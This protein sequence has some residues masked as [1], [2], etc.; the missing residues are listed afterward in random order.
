M[1]TIWE[2]PHS[3]AVCLRRGE[4]G[5]ER[6]IGQRMLTRSIRDISRQDVDDVGGKAA[7]L[8]ELSGSGL[9]VP[10]GFVL[11]TAGYH[12]FV[13]ANTLQDQILSLAA[14]P[15]NGGRP[16]DDAVSIQIGRLFEAGEIP[17]DVAVA[18]CAAYNRLPGEGP[19]RVAVRSSATA[20]DLPEASFAG[21]QETYLNVRGTEELLEAVKKCWASL[22]TTRAIAYRRRLNIDPGAVSLAVVVQQQIDSEVSGVGFSLNP[23]TNDYDEAV[24]DANWGLGESVVAGRVSPDHFVVDKIGRRVLEKKLGAKQVAIWASPD[25]GTIERQDHQSSE[26]TLS[27]AQLDD[28]TDVMCRIETHYETP[29]DIE[30]AYAGGELYVLQARP[31]TAYVPLPPEMVTKPGERRR[32]YADAALSKGLTTNEPI[33]PLGLSWIE[34]VYAPLMATLLG[35]DFS[36]AKGLVFAAGSR[37]YMN[38]SNFM[39]LGMSTRAMAKNAAQTDALLGQILANIDPQQHRAATRPGWLRLRLLLLAPKLVWMLRRP[40]WNTLWNLLT[41]ESARRAYQREIDAFAAEMT[42]GLDYD[43]PLKQFAR[44]YTHRVWREMGDVTMPALLVGLISPAFLI[45][46]GSKEARALVPRLRQGFTGNLVVEQGIALFRLSKLLERTDFDNI[47]RLAERLERREMPPEFLR[48]WDAFLHRFGCRGPHEMDVASPRYADDMTLA[49]QQMSYMSSGE[50]GFDPEA[51]HQRNVEE[52]RRAYEELITRSGWLRRA[53]VRRVHRL[54]ESFGGTRDTPKY[55][56]VMLTHAVH[57]RALVE[58]TRLVSEGRLDSAMDVFCLTLDDLETAAHD[59]ALD[60]RE[61]CK[62]RTR[63][64]KR[65]AAHVTR[66]PQVIDSRGRIFRPP[67]RDEAAGEFVGIAVSPGTATGPVRLLHNP[68][69]TPVHQGDVIVAYTTDPGWT[70]LFVNASAVVLEVGG[71]L[72]HGAVIAREYGKPCVVGID[73]VTTKLRDGQI[74]EVDGTTGVVRLLSSSDRAEL[75]EGQ[76]SGFR[77]KSPR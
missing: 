36:P 77:S 14:T 42:E 24:I 28:L 13:E 73:R 37:L 61:L 12:L 63:F 69:D 54:I 41:P 64:A 32:L 40:V 55:H 62:E 58:G 2:Q 6:P 3:G 56:A 7:N 51:A 9:R 50:S 19:T 33:S 70:P 53:L 76:E 20:E 8:G 43:L 48:D 74:V 60:L 52:R 29:M 47:D 65:L 11:T 18:I 38:V 34:H 5:L 59:P 75:A 66:F 71:V 35:M 25:G 4:V 57:K 15:P 1:G 10:P 27:D 23:L 21:Q 68:R 30:W 49:L 31:I 17:V 72:Q 16:V 67:P 26:C 44:L 45:P 22:W 39:R 46:R